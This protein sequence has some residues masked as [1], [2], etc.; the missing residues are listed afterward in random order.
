MKV[1]TTVCLITQLSVAPNESSV[2]IH[3][4]TGSELGMTDATGE[5]DGS[6]NQ[7]DND[8][9]NVWSEYEIETETSLVDRRL[10][11]LKHG[12]AFA[13]LRQFW[14]HRNRSKHAGGAVLPGHSLPLALRVA[15]RRQKTASP[16]LG[17]ARG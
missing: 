17:H 7:G 13:V 10:R 11:T 4:I 14:R 2:I 6:T 5:L 9:V 1:R 8:V 16:E 15:D 12:D 3:A